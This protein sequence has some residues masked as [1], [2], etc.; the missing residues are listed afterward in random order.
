MRCVPKV[1]WALLASSSAGMARRKRALPMSVCLLHNSSNTLIFNRAFRRGFWLA[2]HTKDSWM[3]AFLVMRGHEQK[4]KPL[5]ATI[6]FRSQHEMATTSG[7]ISAEGANSHLKI[8]PPA[9]RRLCTMTIP[10]RRASGLRD[11]LENTRELFS[12][13]DTLVLPILL[14]LMSRDKE[15]PIPRP[16]KAHAV[17]LPD[18]LLGVLVVAAQRNLVLDLHHLVRVPRGRRWIAGV[19]VQCQ[20]SCRLVLDAFEELELAWVDGD[21]DVE[22]VLGGPGDWIDSDEAVAPSTEFVYTRYAA[23]GLGHGGGRKLYSLWLLVSISGFEAA[24]TGQGVPVGR[25][26]AEAGMREVSFTGEAE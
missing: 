26:V 10:K 8:P 5:S 4:R 23:Y 1:S 9:A 19:Q 2:A 14:N 20:L 13:R 17:P 12:G 24:M 22:F 7:E 16:W 18:V 6:L 3:N 11:A 15:A 21:L 25:R